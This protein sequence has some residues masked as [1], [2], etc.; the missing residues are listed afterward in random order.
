[1]L[2]LAGPA[3]AAFP[4]RNGKIAFVS[5]PSNGA[6]TDIFTVN[7][8]GSGQTNLTQSTEGDAAP[9]WS[10]DGR[11]IAFV[12][13]LPAFGPTASHIYV[14]DADGS[15][16]TDVT[17][18]SQ[19]QNGPLT[20]SPDGSRLAF[21]RTDSC[22]TFDCILSLNTINANGTGETLLTGNAR[23]MTGPS[24]TADGA[25][26][27]FNAFYW[28]TTD[29][30]AV[31][32][33]IRPDG[34]GLTK[35]FG[36]ATANVQDPDVSPDGSKIALY[37]ADRQIATINSDGSGLATLTD[38]PTGQRDVSPVWS[39]DGSKI[40]F[41]TWGASVDINVM[42]SSDGTGKTLISHGYTPDWQPIQEPRR[43]DYKNAAQFCKA[44][45]DFLGDDDAFR[46]RYGGGANA[47]G[48]C[49]SGKGA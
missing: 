38:P 37:Y 31:I 47:Y 43:E 6:N 39:P 20:W 7:P 45:R 22:D 4:G 9:A 41:V 16:Q 27:V 25:W 17:P 35:V 2:A 14:M 13:Y 32:Y 29:T 10:A 48:K 46:Q 34:T 21:I 36:S 8:D 5:V 15:G 30:D 11:K 28:E 12:R 33:K 44:Q 40:A 1:M 49:V 42:N 19:K 3:H 24:W 23:S 18:L 26:I